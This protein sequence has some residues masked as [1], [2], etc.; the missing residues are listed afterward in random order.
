MAATSIEFADA[1][2]R[3]RLL[4]GIVAENAGRT[5][6]AIDLYIEAVA[7]L[8]RMRAGLS[9][10]E[11]R[12]AFIDNASIQE[13]YRRLIA[14]LSAT[15]Q[16]QKAWDYLERGKARSFLEMLQGRRFR[17]G[18]I[19]EESR[20]LRAIEGEII[21]LRAQLG[22]TSGSGGADTTR[23]IRRAELRNA[24]ARFAIAR[25]RAALQGS[26]TGQELSLRP[27]RIE[28]VQAKLPPR[29]ALIEYA[30]LDNRITAFVITR[31]RAV[32]A[33][34]E[35]DLERLRSQVAGARELLGHPDENDALR[36]LLASLS[37]ALIEPVLAQ[38]PDD[39]E[40][41]LLV[42]ANFLN[43]VPFQA[44][45]LEA[46]RD[47]IDR[48]AIAYLPSASALEFLQP[49][50]SARGRLFLGA[51]GNV[52]VDHAAALPGTLKEV[53]GIAQTRANPQVA[54]ENK[55]TYNRVRR[56]LT[57]DR[58]VHLA[59]HGILNADAPLFNAL[60]TSPAPGQPSRLSLY[61]LTQMKL[62]A[63]LV[64]LSACETGLGELRSGDEIT[65][66]TRMFLQAG[67]DTVV[68]SL[69]NVSDRTTAQLMKSF[70]QRLNVG[71]SP[72]VAL[73]S[74]ALGVRK[75]FPHPYYWAPFVLTGAR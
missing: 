59:T 54:V 31:R 71:Q 67:A 8:D 38:V 40:T 10:Q 45:P 42:P 29:T 22:E 65:S 72:A 19:A 12:Q 23:D 24:E 50:N 51:I 7:K 6:E 60:I 48:F 56:A 46:G 32:Q 63:Q 44:L 3:V 34:W 37:A 62:G 15:G 1:Q 30:L 5:S 16:K 27:F 11:Q 26:R 53:Q 58:S 39:V 33:L 74:A 18:T 28:E 9:Q 14:L 20:E 61:E 36:P 2:W 68:A 47:V 57:E 17:A 52:S 75:R 69:W 13:L 49:V 70:Y 41:L 64:V 55:F 4:Q 21:N 73:R 66:L 25:Q 43:Y 35:T